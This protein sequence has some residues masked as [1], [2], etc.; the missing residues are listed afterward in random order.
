MFL[1]LSLIFIFIDV[2]DFRFLGCR[3]GLIQASFV[4]LRGRTIKKHRTHL[5]LRI[6]RAT[7]GCRP[8]ERGHDGVEGESQQGVDGGNMEMFVT[9]GLGRV[10][11]PKRFSR[12]GTGPYL[13]R[14]R[15]ANFFLHQMSYR[16]SLESRNGGIQCSFRSM[17]PLSV[18]KIVLEQR[19]PSTSLVLFQMGAQTAKGLRQFYLYSILSLLSLL[20]GSLRPLLHLQP[21]QLGLGTTD[22]GSLVPSLLVKGIA[23]LVERINLPLA[24]VLIVVVLG[25][26]ICRPLA[27]SLWSN[28]VRPAFTLNGTL[29]PSVNCSSLVKT[30][31]DIR[32]ADG[33]VARATDLASDSPRR[34]NVI[35][36]FLCYILPNKSFNIPS[37][38]KQTGAN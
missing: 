23:A 13:M 12:A 22:G 16:Q 3:S 11:C 4:S 34:V 37:R 33:T 30:L 35:I 19:S 29:R 9:F 15:A 17:R 18:L 20:L 36:I 28:C 26:A 7:R 25:Q 5:G 38:I 1:V 31:G 14:T 8:S 21:Q 32:H 10:G 24:L 6:G 2:N 27:V